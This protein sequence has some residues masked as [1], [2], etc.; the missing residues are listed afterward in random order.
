MPK[1]LVLVLLLVSG[2]PLLSQSPSNRPQHDAKPRV[3]MNAPL[4]FVPSEKPS[5][6]GVD[7]SVNGPSYAVGLTSGFAE[8]A[9]AARLDA[10]MRA[11]ANSQPD[12]IR[13]TLVGAAK[14]TPIAQGE[15]ASKANIFQGKNSAKWRTDVPMYGR[16]LYR[17]VYPGVDVAYYGSQ[18][19]L[20][21]DFVISPKSQPSSIGL[22][23]QGASAKLDQ[24]GNLELTTPS[25]RAMRFEKPVM[26]QKSADGSRE[27]VAGSYAMGKDGTVG[28]NVGAYDTSR[29][30]VI[31]PVLSYASFLGGNEYDQVNSSAVSPQGYLYVTGYT[32]YYDNSGAEIFPTTKNAFQPSCNWCLHGENTAF[33]SKFNADGTQLIYSTFLEGSYVSGQNSGGGAGYAIAASVDDEAYVFGVTFDADFPLVNPLQSLCRAQQS[34]PCSGSF[35]ISRLNPAGNA[36]LYSTFFGNNSG[37]YV[38]TIGLDQEKN[39]VLSGSAYAPGGTTDLPITKNAYQATFTAGIAFPF[40]TEISASGQAV[41]YST[42]LGGETYCDSGNGTCQA[43][44]G[45]AVLSNGLIYV[46]GS[47][48]AGDFPV[49]SNAYQGSCSLN[50]SGQPEC[51]QMNGYLAIFDPTGA[52]GPESAKTVTYIHGP[53]SGSDVYLQSLALDHS[54]NIFLAGDTQDAKWPVNYAN[55][56]TPGTANLVVK[57]NPAGSAK[58]AS[59]YLAGQDDNAENLPSYITTDASGNVYT[60]FQNNNSSLPMVGSVQTTNNSKD[61]QIVE[62]SNDLSKILFSTYVGGSSAIVPAGISVDAARNIYVAGQTSYQGADF[63]TTAGAYQTAYPGG[64]TKVIV[65]KLGKLYPASAVTISVSPSTLYANT[66]VSI[67]ADVTASSGTP[68]G[69]VAFYGDGL[70]IETAALSGGSAKIQVP[71]GGFGSGT[72]TA[73]AIYLGNA[74]LGGSV[75]SVTGTVHAVPTATALTVNPTT[76]PS[77]GK[78]TLVA[79]VTRTEGSGGATGTV[80]FLAN[81]TFVASAN[82][83]S[84]VATLSTTTAGQ[85][86]GTYSVTAQYLGDAT[87]AGSK[88]APVAV[89]LQ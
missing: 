29:D 73:Q 69:N 42:W 74:T 28:F 82:L 78:V 65:E 31:D 61:L 83:V 88:S 19:S 68:T 52:T 89:T 53:T 85:S 15:L 24:T 57:M 4:A 87:D 67:T 40:V 9:L 76:V 62:Q 10:H 18:G 63:I 75:A 43:Y 36:L 26:Y 23:F 33:V 32:Y 64:E 48:E 51:N 81:G 16:I 25:G 7:F 41:V 13:M 55:G 50:T 6:S 17:N 46:T 47:T 38:A 21:Y 14:Q 12:F 66:T 22:T 45:Q 79:K 70:F 39:I 86:A 58:L 37:G 5:Q 8:L 11:D 60:S 49:T 20:E 72:H 1:A 27:M 59:A 3:S 56:Y 84:G 44:P 71:A 77:G 2:S 80:N 54:G 35:F 30:L 34:P